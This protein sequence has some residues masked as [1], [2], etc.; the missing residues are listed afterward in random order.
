M[1]RV[2]TILTLRFSRLILIAACLLLLA[3][4]RISAQSLDI[5]TGR[6]F[7][8]SQNDTGVALVREGDS[9]GDGK[10]DLTTSTF[11]QNDHTL[12]ILLGN[13]DGTFQP[14]ATIATN[15]AYVGV[16]AVGDFNGD[17]HFDFVTLV[18]LTNT[19]SVFLGNGDGT[20]QNP[21]TTT[22]T[23]PPQ[24]EGGLAAADFNGDGKADIA[25]MANAPQQG[26][27][28]VEILI[29]NGDGTF[30]TPVGYGVSSGGLLFVA[31][32]TGNGN[33]DLLTSGFSVLLG[34]G[35]GTF[36]AEKIVTHGGCGSDQGM[37]VG[38]FNRDGKD[39]FAGSGVVE[40]S[41]GDG[42]FTHVCNNIVGANVVAD[43]NH[44]RNPDLVTLASG[45]GASVY[46][47]KG[48]GTFQPPLAFQSSLSSPLINVGPL[49][50]IDFNGDGK[51]DLAGKGEGNTVTVV[52]GNGDGTFR[53]HAVVPAG[54]SNLIGFGAN[55]FITADLRNAGIAD[56][57]LF[58]QTPI[59]GLGYV[60]M[61]L[62]NG[63]GHVPTPGCV[64]GGGNGLRRYCG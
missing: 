8:A 1:P 52:L 36:Q 61:L 33:H 12:S 28:T 53:V 4:A 51:I 13:G 32:F 6:N 46:L 55:S 19:I 16:L 63:N 7:P 18:P 54:D 64:R 29:S 47:G 42:T 30:K 23:S 25:L 49:T 34:N 35:D 20:F 38:D 21:I 17:G 41:N 37:A 22:L 58:G 26:A 2:R 40:L 60:V 31:D 62:G 15:A 56:F 57:L 24:L 3:S 43:F 50:A 44:D 59:D 48:D 45:G 39:D 11:A 5:I 10:A 27:G 9:N 14:S